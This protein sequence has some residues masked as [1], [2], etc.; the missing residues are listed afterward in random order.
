M[1][2]KDNHPTGF[3]LWTNEGRRYS[4]GHTNTTAKEVWEGKGLSRV[5]GFASADSSKKDSIGYLEFVIASNPTWFA[6]LDPTDTQK[7]KDIKSKL[8]PI[9]TFCAGADMECKYGYIL[10]G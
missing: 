10:D 1:F 2:E 5:V 4:F 9:K 6:K 8:P 3:T 7:A